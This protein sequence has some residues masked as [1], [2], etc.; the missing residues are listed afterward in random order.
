MNNDFSLNFKIENN[1]E[2]VVNIRMKSGI[3][4]EIAENKKSAYDKGVYFV[5]QFRNMDLRHLTLKPEEALTKLDKEILIQL[6]KEM[7][8]TPEQMMGHDINLVNQTL[9]VRIALTQYFVERNEAIHSELFG[10]TLYCGTLAR[11]RVALNTPKESLL[12]L[13]DHDTHSSVS[14]K[15]RLVDPENIY[16]Q[17]WTT[18]LGSPEIIQRDPENIGTPGLYISLAGNINSPKDRYYAF[19]ELD[20]KV[21]KEL[22]IY[23][24]EQL[25]KE[26]GSVRDLLEMEK[27]VVN[28][29]KQLKSMTEFTDKQIERMTQLETKNYRLTLA[30][31]ADK[32]LSVFKDTLHKSELS[33]LK[34]KSGN[35]EF[36]DVVKNMSALVGLGATVYKLLA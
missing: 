8:R 25:A 16:G 30:Q 12:A 31:D 35:N 22:G 28:L 9:N 24:T 19:S 23:P 14:L 21:L 17:L 13:I 6:Q 36:G 27:K 3:S 26:G 11:T 20:D 7:E 10:I 29:D 2:K 1:S 18:V 15:I 5:A 34:H 32:R 4:Y 33:F